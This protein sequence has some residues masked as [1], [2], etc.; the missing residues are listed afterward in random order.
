MG[1]NPHEG[2]VPLQLGKEQMKKGH[3]THGKMPIRDDVNI[4][5]QMR[6]A[7]NGVNEVEMSEAPTGASES[8]KW[9]SPK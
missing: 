5:P 7:P 1:T 8:Q 6:K 3:P 2:M 4:D 9:G